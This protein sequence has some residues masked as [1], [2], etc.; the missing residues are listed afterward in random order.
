MASAG[1][2]GL[3][4]YDRPVYTAGLLTAESTEHDEIHGVSPLALAERE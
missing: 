1:Y 3:G 4:V 2:R